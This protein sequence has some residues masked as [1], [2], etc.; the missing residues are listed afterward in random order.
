VWLGFKGNFG[1]VG[2]WV[3]VQ[4]LGLRVWGFKVVLGC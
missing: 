2:F 4:V 1:V 3:R